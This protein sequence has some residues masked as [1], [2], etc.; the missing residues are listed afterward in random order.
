MFDFCYTHQHLPRHLFLSSFV[1][2]IILNI[3]ENFIHYNNGKHID[4]NQ[5]FYMELPSKHDMIKIVF[6]MFIFA[7]LQGLF[8]L[9]LYKFTKI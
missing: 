6:V 4:S 9:F 2:F 8:T 5:L 7:I 3:I 1:A